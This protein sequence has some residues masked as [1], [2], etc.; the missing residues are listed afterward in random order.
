MK[1]SFETLTNVRLKELGPSVQPDESGDK[2]AYTYIE[3]QDGRMLNK[4]E[5]NT[6]LIG[7]I[8]QALQSGDAIDLHLMKSSDASLGTGIMAIKTADGRLFAQNIPPMPGAALAGVI[9][10]YA[11]GV[12]TIPVFGAG[13]ILIWNARKLHKT[14]GVMAKVRDHV[15]GLPGAI[16]L[17]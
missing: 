12:F 2:V 13:L 16:F 1:L 10:L 11:F 17:N 8:E 9:F 5:V 15:H 14:M 6:A 7:K 4:V 3:L